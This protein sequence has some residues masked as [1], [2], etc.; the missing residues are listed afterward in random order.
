MEAAA[1]ARRERL[2]ALRQ[3][4][5]DEDAGLIAPDAPDARLAI[6]RTFRNYDPTTGQAR[7]RHTALLPSD[8]VENAVR[9]LQEAVIAEDDIKRDQDLD[10]LNIAPKKPNWDLKRDMEKRLAK[11]ERRDQEARMVL[12][13]QRIAATRGVGADGAGARSADDN[14]AA[15]LSKVGAEVAAS[16]AKDSGLRRLLVGYDEVHDEDADGDSDGSEG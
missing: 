15:A 14:D 1:A 5:A 10:L 8:T 12:I 3:R 9:G 6:K 11:L 13:R 4:R 2:L 7:T 16:A